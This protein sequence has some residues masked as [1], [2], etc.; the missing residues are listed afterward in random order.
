MQIDASLIRYNSFEKAQQN[1]SKQDTGVKQKEELSSSEQAQLQKL[2]N[3][4][5]QVRAHEAAHIA[6]GGGI[7]TGGANF[8]YQEGPDGK[9]Y[10][11]GGEVPID[12]R[13]EN[14]PEQTID[15][16]QKVR[17]AALAPS[18]PSSTDYKVAST[19]TM[20]ESRAR[21]ELNQQKLEELTGKKIYGENEWNTDTSEEVA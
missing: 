11:I 15:K 19:A 6:A 8:T 10:A 7:V 1:S 12:A 16:M 14:K 13:P 18:D 2:Q 4:D 3:S 21:M 9:L 20:L 17:A 5:T